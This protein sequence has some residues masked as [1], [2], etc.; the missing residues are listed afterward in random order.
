MATT[1]AA[2][3]PARLG[4]QRFPGKVLHLFQ[5]KPLLFYVWKSVTRCRQ[6]SRVAI[7]TDSREIERRM[8]EFGAEVIMTGAGYRTGSDRVAA[9][10]D[11]VRADLY[12][13]VQADCFGLKAAVLDKLVLKFMA[14]KKSQFGTLARRFESD[15]ELFDPNIVKVI[16]D[17]EDQALWFSRFPLPFVQDQSPG[18]RFRQFGFLKHI[19][20]YLFSKSGLRKFAAW[21]RE[22]LEKA[23]SLE[24]LRILCN[25]ERM[26]VYRT[27]MKTVSVDRPEDLKK[28]ENL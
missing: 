21:P 14:D 1:V 9:V 27:N 6:V 13:N 7:A 2:I 15:D 23:E 8:G 20:I 5:G 19:G 16:L 26:A 18:E 22:K 4:S 24:Q 28:I 25:R 12:L 3:I 17:R 10:A 11:K